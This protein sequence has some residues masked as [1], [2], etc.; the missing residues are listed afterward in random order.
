MIVL[1]CGNYCRFIEVL[2]YDTSKFVLFEDYFGSLR[3]PLRSHM[4]I[5]M[6]FYR[7]H[8]HRMSFHL[9]MS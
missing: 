2:K 3:G 9:F 6:D 1:H 8:E 7:V 5:R 4:T